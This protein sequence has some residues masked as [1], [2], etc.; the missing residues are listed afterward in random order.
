V[1]SPNFVEYVDIP[2]QYGPR[3]RGAK[4]KVPPLNLEQNMI[5]GGGRKRTRFDQHALQTIDGT[6]TSKNSSQL[7]PLSFHQKRLSLGHASRNPKLTEK[8]LR[9]LNCVT[10]DVPNFDV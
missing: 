9:L 10:T 3:P 6:L 2:I 5:D 7:K 8:D 4:D 1:G